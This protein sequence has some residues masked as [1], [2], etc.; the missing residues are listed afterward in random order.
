MSNYLY[1]DDAEFEQIQSFTEAI[2]QQQKEL[3]IK[4]QKPKRF[5]EEIEKLAQA[6]NNREFDRL[7][8][9]LWLHQ[10][11]NEKGE[12]ANY[13]ATTLAQQIRTL[14]TEGKLKEFPIALW[15]DDQKLKKSYSADESAHDLFDL[16]CP[17]EDL[18]E[19]AKR[20][21]I[22]LQLESLVVGYE[23]IRDIRKKN[24]R[25]YKFLGFSE[26]PEFLDPRINEFL[27]AREGRPPVHEYARF[28]LKE[29]LSVQGVLIDERTL[30][31]RLGVDYETSE[32]WAKLKD[33]LEESKYIGVFKEG[34]LRWW[35][36]SLENWWR[37]L[38]ADMPS[39]R[40]T[41]ASERIKLIRE[42]T[43]LR[44]LTAAKPIGESYSEAYWTVCQATHKPLDPRDGL[45]IDRPNAKLWQDK[46]YVSLEAELNRERQ[47]KGLKL[48]PIDKGRRP[49]L[50]A[51]LAAKL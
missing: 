31:A 3:S 10:F 17:K 43:K 23:E 21:L 44:E 26:L 9:D 2:K 38:S 8:L 22:A 7:I 48:D 51:R 12:R 28:I 46:L 32:S 20:S 41:P 39:L 24:T 15:S 14:G 33:C 25:L 47:L 49:K 40:T 19:K 5:D 29:L 34:W 35:A 4:H 13:R 30:A 16:V 11:V 36:A 37:S 6:F 27:E 50:E 18:A 45:I 1:L 42:H